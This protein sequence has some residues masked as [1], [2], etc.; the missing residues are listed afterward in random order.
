MC[1]PVQKKSPLL[2]LLLLC[3]A[4]GTAAPATAQDY[5]PLRDPL[6]IEQV[7]GA[8]IYYTVGHPGVPS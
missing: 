5:P 4:L 8:P 3:L 6:E 2:A 7:P 1:P